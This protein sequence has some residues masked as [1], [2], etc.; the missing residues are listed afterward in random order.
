[1]QI[2]AQKVCL[3][4]VSGMK[5]LNWIKKFGG[6][7]GSRQGGCAVVD[8]GEEVLFGKKTEWTSEETRG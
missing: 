2:N 8:V 7:V 3:L 6:G 5:N 1:M 4:Q